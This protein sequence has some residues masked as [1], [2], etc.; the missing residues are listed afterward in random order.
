MFTIPLF[1]RSSALAVFLVAMVSLVQGQTPPPEGPEAVK[2]T[3]ARHAV[4]IAEADRNNDVQQAISLRLAL[5]AMSKPKDALALYTRAV[6]I[7]DSAHLDAEAIATRQALART[8][9]GRG[10]MKQAYQEAIRAAEHA[11]GWATDRLAAAQAKR[12][13]L[14]RAMAIDRDSLLAGAEAGRRATE[15]RV[16]EANDAARSWMWVAAGVGLLA[17]A[18]IGFVLARYGRIIRR[19]RTEVVELRSDLR[20][21]EERP[22]NRLRGPAV[23]AAPSVP[24]SAGAERSSTPQNAPLVID[25]MV[26]AMF[27]KQAPMRLITLREA[28]EQGD[29]EKV[30]RVVHTLKPQLLVFDD[31]LAP[32][33]MRIIRENAWSEPQQW[34]ADLDQVEAAVDRILRG[35]VTPG[36]PS[37]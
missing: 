22:R 37:P 14:L 34:N 33:C 16:N 27:Q 10:Q 31:S 7:A 26:R 4:A 24:E 11:A 1:G 29:Q 2:A 28:R 21:M 20:S 9:A 3:M 30:Q 19:L 18:I 8:L 25:P 15:V 6:A 23:D 5:A 13:S 17:L 12:D 36:S 35:A 32:L